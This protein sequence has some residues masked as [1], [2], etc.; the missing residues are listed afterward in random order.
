[1]K[2][3]LMRVCASRLCPFNSHDLPRLSMQREKIELTVSCEFV[4]FTSS[5]RHKEA[6]TFTTINSWGLGHNG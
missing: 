3:Y 6:V 1:M 4:A 5:C 2:W